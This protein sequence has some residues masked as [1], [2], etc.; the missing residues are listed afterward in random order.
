MKLWLN[1]G[2]DYWP[3]KLLNIACFFYLGGNGLV[4]A[5]SWFFWDLHVFPLLLHFL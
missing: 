1:V 2:L 3:A 4:S 5:M